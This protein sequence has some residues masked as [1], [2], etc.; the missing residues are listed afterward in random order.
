MPTDIGIV[1]TLIGL[2]YEFDLSD[3]KNFHDSIRYMF[4]DLP[5]VTK[6]DNS[7]RELLEE[8][9]KY[10]IDIGLIP[11]HGGDEL[12]EQAIVEHRPR[13]IGAF[14]VDPNLGMESVRALE[15]AYERFGVKAAQ[16]MPSGVNPPVPI[17]D[18]RA[19]PLYAKCVELDIPIM[20]NGGVPGPYVPYDVQHPG[21]VDDVCLYFPDLKF[22]FRHC[23]EPW[24]DLT[25]KL[26]LKYPNLYYST[27]GFAPR[28]YPEQIIHFANTRGADK[29]LYGGYYPYGLPLERIFAELPYVPLKDEV[30]PKFLRENAA[31]VLKLDD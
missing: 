25:I 17:N 24:V 27:T 6:N 21:L 22:V 30:W 7:A 8:M 11:V 28:W 15:D 10:G 12:E 1:D 14:D 23:C 4:K 9:D 13:L 16:W 19:Y 26:L 5:E 20:V 18:K 31:R 2:P 29:I 3:P